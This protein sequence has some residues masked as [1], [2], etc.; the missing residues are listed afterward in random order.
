MTNFLHG[1]TA[2][3]AGHGFDESGPYLLINDV[4]RAEQLRFSVLGKTF[5]LKRLPRRRCV[6]RFDLET[7]VKSTCPLNVELLPDAKET[8][9]PACIEAT[10]F[11]PSFY[12]ADFISA[13]QRAYNLTPHFT[14]LAYFSPQHVKAG[15]SS[16]TRGIE[17]LLEQGAR[18]ARIVGRFGCADDA[19]E[20]EAALCSQQGV[21]ETMRA[22]VKTKLLV[23]ARFDFS[24]AKRVLDATA[25]RLGLEDAE[26]AQ[27]LSPYYF[28]GPSPDVHDL[29]IPDG[30]E[31]ECGGRCIGMVGGALVFEQSGAN[32]VVAVKDWESHEVELL[33]D[34]VI[35]EY[36]F[37]PQQFSLF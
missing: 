22:S 10:G 9:C 5:S 16:E 37:E 21:L 24:E 36:A 15:I 7:Q 6:G 29:Q 34:E 35:C 1:R 19:R 23:E 31:G 30:H 20:L 8:M 11:N 18:A 25:E 3:L 32:Y 26:P 14:Y 13:Q 2:V 4:D 27:D 17:R 28:G 12:Y 33:E